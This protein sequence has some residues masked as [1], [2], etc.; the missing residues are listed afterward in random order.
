MRVEHPRA[1]DGP[2]VAPATVDVDSESVPVEDGIFEVDNEGWLRRFAE[3]HGTTP[4]NIVYEEDGPPDGSSEEPCVTVK[5]DGE[6]C[7]R[8][9]PCPYHSDDYPED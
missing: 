4:E 8:E 3:R 6:V 1:G 9:L 5:S 2:G 7:G